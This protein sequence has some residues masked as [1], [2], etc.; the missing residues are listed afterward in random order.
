MKTYA[1]KHGISTHQR[2][3]IT[4]ESAKLKKRNRGKKTFPY[5]ARQVTFNLEKY[6]NRQ[7]MDPYRRQLLLQYACT[8]DYPHEA[9][10]SLSAAYDTTNNPLKKAFIY[11]ERNSIG[12]IIKRCHT[13]R[14]K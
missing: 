6:T 8:L 3:K 12:N 1:N 10:Q 13:Y 14:N 4:Q 9:L 2:E 5:N 7:Q 11:F